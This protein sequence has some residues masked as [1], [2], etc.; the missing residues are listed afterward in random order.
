M[1]TVNQRVCASHTDAGGALKL[2]SALD[3][4]Q[5]CSQMWLES[6]PE[7]DRFF[8]DN[9]IAQMLVSRQADIRRMPLYG[10]KLLVET[11]VYECKNFLGYRNTVI[12]DEQHNPCVVTW[13]VGAFV[14]LATGRPEKLPAPVLASVHYDPKFEMEYLGKKIALPE[15]STT[16]GSTPAWEKLPPVP[17]KRNDIDFNRHMNNARYVQIAVDLLPPDFAISRFRI[18]YKT[19]AKYG[20]LLYPEIFCQ[21]G[22]S[23]KPGLPGQAGAGTW[24]LLLNNGEEDPKAYTV[25]EFC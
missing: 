9:N 10:E 22:H 11:R 18:E 15:L 14:N 3:M 23:E 6:E 4:I 25:M 1:Y 12:Y 16:S 5:D 20:D 21:P 24:F 13:S 19:P 17:V 2:V 8:R 7:L